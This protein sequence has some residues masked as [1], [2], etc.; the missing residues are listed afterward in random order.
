[1]LSE[2]GKIDIALGILK[3]VAERENKR[4]LRN[5][6]TTFSMRNLLQNE[7]IPSLQNELD[8]HGR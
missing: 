6:Q 7:V 1:M 8:C 3:G 2:Y 4:S 5:R